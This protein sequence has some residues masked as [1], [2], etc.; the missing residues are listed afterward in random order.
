M[1]VG[2]ADG[3]R[4]GWVVCRR[5]PSG[6]LDIRVVKTLEEACEG[7]SILAVDMPIG[8]VDH[9]RPPRACEV[10]ARKLLPGKASSVFPTPCRPALAC[11]THAEANALSRTMGVGINRQTFHL[12]PK[13]R[14]VDALMRGNRRLH[15]IV[16]EAHPELA[17]A[18]MNGGQPVLSKKH[19]PDGYTERRK[20]L[21]RHGFRTKVE[22][23]SGAARDDILDAIAV[24]RTATLIAD[25]TATRLG[26]ADERDRHGLPMNIWF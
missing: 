8:F 7:L 15:R 10:E 18:R 9:P 20:L 19:Q 22:R 14:E 16:Y 6:T 26:P 13:M 3:C 1:I 11:T 23:L 25:G 17:F 2:G 24:C 21:A 12:F 4:T 5:D